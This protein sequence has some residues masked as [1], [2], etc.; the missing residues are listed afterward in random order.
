MKNKNLWKWGVAG[1]VLTLCLII[2]GTLNIDDSMVYFYTPEE[3]LA[4]SEEFS[5]KRIRIGALVKPGSIDW[6]AEELVLN[7][8]VID[9]KG[10]E[11]DVSFKGTP[12]DLFKENQGVVV[13]GR[14][15]PDGKSFAAEN[16]LVKHSEEYKKPDDHSRMEKMLLE[17]SLFKE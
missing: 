7:F 5:K 16:L 8:Q 13:E 17:E 14:I 11:L 9:T 10:N 3:A 12:P 6:Q 15:A 2:L 1:V 4:K